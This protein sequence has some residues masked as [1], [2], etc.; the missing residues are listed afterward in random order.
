M[1]YEGIHHVN[2]TFPRRIITQGMGGEPWRKY[3]PPVAD[4][5]GDLADKPWINW[6]VDPAKPGE[7][8]WLVW[9]NDT[10]YVKRPNK[11]Y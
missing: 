11:A 3:W 1:E 2:G 7:K 6:K 5:P 10:K 9:M 8:P 4:G